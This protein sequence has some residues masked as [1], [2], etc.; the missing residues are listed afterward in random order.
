METDAQPPFSPVGI[1]NNVASGVL[2]ACR[3]RLECS[4][5]HVLASEVESYGP[6]IRIGRDG[7]F[8][9]RNVGAVPGAA[10]EVRRLGSGDCQAGGFRP[11]EWPVHY[12]A[13]FESVCR[14]GLHAE[15]AHRGCLRSQPAHHL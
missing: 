4:V 13:G 6:T 9:W 11:E 7:Y 12:H 15:V 3:L 2:S 14:K 1:A 5:S 10:P 8:R